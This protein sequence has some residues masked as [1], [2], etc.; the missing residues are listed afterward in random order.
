MKLLVYGVSMDVFIG[1]L[2]KLVESL[3][4]KRDEFADSQETVDSR[5]ESDR[6]IAMIES[7]TNWYAYSRFDNEVLVKAGLNND[8]IKQVRLNGKDSIPY[9]FRS[10]VCEYQKMAIIDNY[11]EYNTY[12]RMLNGEPIYRKEDDENYGSDFVYVKENEYGIPT[13]I[14]VHLLSDG[15]L[16]YINTSNLRDELITAHPDKPYLKYLGSRSMDYYHARVAK[17]YELLYYEKCDNESISN[18]FIK[19]YA[20]ARDYV[21][22]GLY[23]RADQKMYEHYD[24]FMG[25]MVV[26][27]AIQKMFHSIFKQGIS[28]DFFDENLIKELFVS[29][30]FPYITTIDIG[31]QKEIAKKLN[32]LLQKKSTNNVLFDIISL[33]DFPNVNIYKYYLVKDYH[34]D[35]KGNPIIIHNTII[36]EYGEEHRVIDYEKTFDI[37]FQKVNIKSKDP[38][39]EL[40]NKS[41]RVP[42]EALTGAD[43]YWLDDSALFTKLYTKKFNQILTKYMS[44]DVS[45]ELSKLL[46]ETSHGLRMMI[47]DNADY[48][49]IKID[50]NGIVEPVSLYDTVVFLCAL[51]ARK[52]GLAGNIPLKG[53]QIA[54][55]YGFNFKTDMDMLK[56]KILEDIETCTG[57]YKKV[58]LETLKY[59]NTLNA[60]TLDGAVK[61]YANIEALRKFLDNA[62]RYSTDIEEYVAY[63][64]LYQSTLIVEDAAELYVKNDGTYANTFLELL[65]DRRPDLYVIVSEIG[66]EKSTDDEEL[67]SGLSQEDLFTIDHTTNS[68]LDKLSK[69]SPKFNE[70]RFANDKSEI[71]ANI[72]K[73]INQLKSYTVDQGASSIVYLI[74][75]PH[76]CLLKFICDLIT[77]CKESTIN[78]LLHILQQDVLHHIEVTSLEQE[79]PEFK[80]DLFQEKMELLKNIMTVVYKIVYSYKNTP[81]KDKNNFYDILDGFYKNVIM[82]FAK[83]HPYHHLHADMKRYP[84]DGMVFHSEEMLSKFIAAF[85]EGKINVDDTVSKDSMIAYVTLLNMAGKIFIEAKRLYFDT[86]S[87][88]HDII[89]KERHNYLAMQ[90]LSVDILLRNSIHPIE[91]GVEIDEKVYK[92]FMRYE[93][94]DMYILD[95]VLSTINGLQANDR[96]FLYNLLTLG[97][98][99]MDVSEK[100]IL[101]HELFTNIPGISLESRAKILDLLFTFVNQK[102][103]DS[104]LTRIL[105]YDTLYPKK[106]DNELSAK[107]SLVEEFITMITYKPMEVIGFNEFLIDIAKNEVGIDNLIRSYD[108]LDSYTQYLLTRE[109]IMDESCIYKTNQIINDD[110]HKLRDQI[111]EKIK[112]GN[113]DDEKKIFDNVAKF[114]TVHSPYMEKLARIDYLTTHRSG[115]N[116][117][118]ILEFKLKTM[119]IVKRSTLRYVSD[120]I[121]A[122]IDNRIDDVN[123]IL[124]MQHYLIR[125]LGYKIKEE[126]LLDLQMIANEKITV[127]RNISKLLGLIVSNDKNYAVTDDDTIISD[128][129]V[130]KEQCEDDDLNITSTEYIH[131]NRDLQSSTS[132]LDNLVRVLYNIITNVFRES[133]V[134]FGKNKN[135]SLEYF[136][137]IKDSLANN[138]RYKVN[139]NFYLTDKLF[140]INE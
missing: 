102:I 81:V 97:M 135:E 13:N 76:M 106:G 115:F 14:P 57:E 28:R 127:I 82:P 12:Y 104:N 119:S 43:P 33:F 92:R 87:F 22:I 79:D 26:V 95:S 24:S 75:D 69:I 67:T 111:L 9:E 94:S 6:Y 23:N 129:N 70:L 44:I 62:M 96:V 118:E 48:K 99:S 30:N 52:F 108:Y 137:S 16:Q 63:W 42:Y 139:D 54:Q 132:T 66:K 93:F 35:N 105:M 90:L 18:D 112:E 86:M 117:S 71:V 50:L 49:R 7:G 98:S 65:Q 100:K 91:T 47:D 58:K 72:E 15:Y 126:L 113:L 10:L 59:L 34:K 116:E 123:M 77:T 32:I 101:T 83:I 3:V 120:L 39:A 17:N 103:C 80:Y 45:Y 36:D 74:R 8:L 138:I 61:M 121:D 29:Y 128:I 27:V 19:N 114:I 38:S 1:Q 122:I 20:A 64:K 41:N 73:V 78:D 107:L 31:Y 60:T 85:N 109:I 21:M 5:R 89:T 133:D 88:D 125:R 2:I 124:N 68:I 53:H 25:M 46:Y 51:M 40:V 131:S 136:L 140:K 56:N 130:N 4:V 55:V 134:V 37:Y 11:V 84:R 110:F